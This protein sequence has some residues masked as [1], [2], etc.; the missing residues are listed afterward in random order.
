MEFKS[1]LVL[2]LEGNREHVCYLNGLTIVTAGLP[3]RHGLHKA[4][5]FFIKSLVTA[6]NNL[7][8]VDRTV[9]SYVER[10]SYTTL[11]AFL[12]SNCG[13]NDVV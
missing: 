8:V 5:S 3:L 4:N 13:I 7:N 9:L 6:A 1:G 12:N 10:Y 11:Y 2:E